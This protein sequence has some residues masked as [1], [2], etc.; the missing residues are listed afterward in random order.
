MTDTIR[1]LDMLSRSRGVVFDFDGVLV[2][3]EP[4]H[5]E[6]IRRAAEPFGWTFTE[7]QFHEFIV[8]R[9]DERCFASLAEWHNDELTEPVL[10]GLLTDKA[11]YFE[12]GVSAGRFVVQ[13]GAVAMIEH[14]AQRF[15]G[16]IAVC[17]GSRKVTVWSILERAGIGG[18]FDQNR[19][20]TAD[21]VK[22]NKPHPDG[23]LLA[24]ERLE[25]APA[26][27]LAIEDTPTGVAAAVSAGLSVIAVEHTV[28][29]DRLNEAHAVV[30]TIADLLGLTNV[31][32]GSTA[33]SDN[34]TT[35]R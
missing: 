32:E 8:G 7:S 17:S 23:Y 31:A 35:D 33:S 14:A 3:S 16:R 34:G 4:L 13:P 2:D 21:D 10:R 5:A 26:H 27:A 11:R 9:G 12:E 24:S 6:A 15:D 19:V 28:T 30:R 20:V 25:L 22:N 18:L 1:A 29:R